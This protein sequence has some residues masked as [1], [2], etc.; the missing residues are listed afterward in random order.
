MNSVLRF[1][2]GVVGACGLLAAGALPAM[3]SAAAATAQRPAASANAARTLQATVSSERATVTSERARE[4]SERVVVTRM[5]ATTAKQE[6]YITVYS[7]PGGSQPIGITE[8]SDGAVW[9]VKHTNPVIGRITA[10]GVITHYSVGGLRS[11]FGIASGSDRALWFVNGDDPGSIGRITTA[12]AVTFFTGGRI[13][14]PDWI[15]AGPDGAL[16]FTNDAGGGYTTPSIERLAT[17]GTLT[18]Y[19][20]PS[21]DAPTGIAAGPDGA[22]WFVNR[23]STANINA[24]SIGR[25]TTSG[26]VTNY[27]YPNSFAPHGIAAGPGNTVWFT[28]GDGGGDGIPW[29]VE[30]MTTS[31]AVTD[32]ANRDLGA[33]GGADLGGGGGIVKGPDGAMW[34][35]D[36]D[37]PT[38][39]IGRMTATGTLTGY[40][41]PGFDVPADEI[42][43]GPGNAL[44]FTMGED[45]IGR[46]PTLVFTSG[47][48]LTSPTRVGTADTCSF[49]SLNATRVAVS[50]LVNGT[51]QKG[52][53][54]RTFTPAAADL[55]KALSCS[56]A[57]ANAGGTLTRKSAAVKVALGA[58]L[59]VE[60]KPMLSG[61]HKAGHAESVSAGTWS[62][63]ASSYSYQWYLGSGKI[64]HAT[65]ARYTPPDR[66]KGA[67]LHCVIHASKAGYANGSYATAAVT[68]S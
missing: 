16:W 58:P 37:A 22:L 26:T 42:A 5:Q 30:K 48:R 57:L 64:A 23:T 54:A 24:G 51:V 40:G 4:R 49:G 18:T 20:D 60:R 38:T 33:V 6:G 21:I 15:A 68:L 63:T 3:T 43:S 61:P 13:S 47:P 27:T 19:T 65:A 32:Y 35:T 17:D 29:S 41:T 25:I 52:A 46:L 53:T 7:D 56:V 28:N 67:K 14:V 10:G 34:L 59:K 50:W 44:W 12:G 8:G 2:V 11:P 9:Y 31:G 39:I 66:D 1:S 62:P 45:G 36:N 55:G